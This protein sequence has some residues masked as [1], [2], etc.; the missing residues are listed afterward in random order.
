MIYQNKHEHRRYSE[1][2][3]IDEEKPNHICIQVGDN[4]A[5]HDITLSKK[6]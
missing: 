4:W 2:I 5:G 1:E 3:R 6:S